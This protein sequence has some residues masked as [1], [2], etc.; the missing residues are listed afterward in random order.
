MERRR[1]RIR[2]RAAATAGGPAGIIGNNQQHEGGEE[3]R[4]P[5]RRFQAPPTLRALVLAAAVLAGGCC[6][7]GLRVDAFR[8]PQPGPSQLL[9]LRARSWSV[10]VPN[11]ARTWTPS[12]GRAR[13]R[14]PVLAATRGGGGGVDGLERHLAA[15][16]WEDEEEEDDEEAPVEQLLNPHMA[17][18][19]QPPAAAPRRRG[20]PRKAEVVVIEEDDEEE[21]GGA[22][23]ARRPAPLQLPASSSSSSSAP[24]FLPTVSRGS[25]R[26]GLPG[27]GPLD[28]AGAAQKAPEHVRPSPNK[29]EE[30]LRRLEAMLA[31]DEA[32]GEDEGEQAAAAG[33]AHTV[34]LYVPPADLDVMLAWADRLMERRLQRGA[35]W[36]LPSGVAMATEEEEAAEEGKQ[37]QQQ[38]RR[39]RGQQQ[40]ARRRAGSKALVALSKEQRL[41]SLAQMFL[42]MEKLRAEMADAEPGPGAVTPRELAGRLGLRPS[43]VEAFYKLGLRARSYILMSMHG[44]IL[45]LARRYAAA[46]GDAVDRAELVQ[47][48]YKGAMQAVERYDPVKGA[49]LAVGDVLVG[50]WLFDRRQ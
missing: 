1:A 21:D 13:G 48:G 15:S 8:P 27:G 4:R 34:D 30:R 12:G 38:Q 2:P 16:L 46:F 11:G 5:L 40:Q 42:G 39:G 3:G 45:S 29:R 43:E 47:E 9:L 10:A 33:R 36:S 18:A 22:G 6:G 31:E 25:A 44:L 26:R 24:R 41:L 7:T 50:W 20:R 23:R 17:A 14:L 35:Q 28:A 32:E 19:A 37:Q 49:W